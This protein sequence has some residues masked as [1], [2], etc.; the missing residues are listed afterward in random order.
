MK[1]AVMA[2][3]AMKSRNAVLAVALIGLGLSIVPARSDEYPTLDV[4]PLCRGITNQSSLQEGL[5]SV[6]FD[7]CLKAEQSDRETMIKEWSSFTADDKRHCIA[8]ATMGGESSYTDLLTCLEMP[9][10]VRAL[11]KEAAQ[12]PQQDTSQPAKP[13]KS[14]K[15][16]RR[17]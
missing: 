12:T 15:R 4:K 1:A 17:T 5:R 7:E 9:R 2:E 6:T 16:K 3:A 8:E 13:R 10:D 14:A 11:H